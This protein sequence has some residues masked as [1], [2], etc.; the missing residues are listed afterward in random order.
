MKAFLADSVVIGGGNAKKL[1]ELPRERGQSH[2]LNRIPGRV[3]HV[4]H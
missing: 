4:E 1:K 2:N 3:P